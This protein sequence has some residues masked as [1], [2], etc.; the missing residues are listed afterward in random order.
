MKIYIPDNKV[1]FSFAL[2][3]SIIYVRYEDLKYLNFAWLWFDVI[4]EFGNART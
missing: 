4:V 3:P 2:T 1:M